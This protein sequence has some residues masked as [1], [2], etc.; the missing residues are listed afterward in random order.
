MKYFF[1]ASFFM[2]LFACKNNEPKNIGADVIQNP[3]TADGKIDST[4]LPHLKFDQ[5]VY[6]FGTIKEGE[7]VSYSF[8]FTNDGKSPLIISNVAATCGCTIPT[9]S[10]DPV[11]PGEKGKIDII[12]NSSGK[13]GLQ[14]KAITI[15]SNTIPN[16]HVLYLRGEVL[17]EK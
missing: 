9:W 17:T 4:K 3:M 10:K 12:F 2:C 14:S 5:E 8:H 11:A 7:K 15:T 6:D 1:I 13:R 16:S